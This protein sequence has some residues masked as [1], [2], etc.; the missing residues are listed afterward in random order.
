[1]RKIRFPVHDELLSPQ[2]AVNLLVVIAGVDSLDDE[3]LRNGGDTVNLSV[4]DPILCFGGRRV[5][6]RR[7]CGIFGINRHFAPDAV[8]HGNALSTTS[9]ILFGHLFS[10]SKESAN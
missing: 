7:H 10:S 9:M 1:M 6:H 4:P 5:Q 8:R 3:D 2:K